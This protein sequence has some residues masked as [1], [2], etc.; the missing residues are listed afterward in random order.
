MARW[1]STSDDQPVELRGAKRRALLAL[2]IL[3][4]NE[5]VRTDR[6]VDELW[7]EHPPANAPAALQNHVSRLRKAL[8]GDVLITKP[9]GYVPRAETDTIDLRRFEKLVAEA[10]T[11]AAQGAARTAE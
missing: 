10:R 9:W 11:L 6:L 1:R 4:A 8:G 2:L 5:V 3:H 7:G